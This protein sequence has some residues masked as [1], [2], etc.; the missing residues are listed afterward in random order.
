MSA[1]LSS[2]AAPMAL[3]F[4]KPLGEFIHVCERERADALA[5][6][7]FVPGRADRC[8]RQ[9]CP[10]VGHR[11]LYA[12]LRIVRQAGE[13][14][15]DLALH[16]LKGRIACEQLFQHRFDVQ[17]SFHIGLPD[18]RLPLD[19]T[20]GCRISSQTQQSASLSDEAAE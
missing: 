6:E 9:D 13:Q 10:H 8:S 2:A 4:D 14:E 15:H 19:T 16:G 18:D 17:V 7:P 5:V 3:R 20:P 11:Q 1:L 12:G